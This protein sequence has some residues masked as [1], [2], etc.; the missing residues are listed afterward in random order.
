MGEKRGGGH[1]FRKGVE[2]GERPVTGDERSGSGARNGDG[3]PLSVRNGTSRH[4][5]FVNQSFRIANEAGGNGKVATGF[6]RARHVFYRENGGAS[7]YGHRSTSCGPIGN[8]TVA[9]R[10]ELERIVVGKV[11]RKRFRKRKGDA[12]TAD[13][14]GGS[15]R[16]ISYGVGGNRGRRRSDR[17]RIESVLLIRVDPGTVLSGSARRKERSRRIGNEGVR[18][19]RSGT[20]K[21]A[22][23]SENL[24]DGRI[25]NGGSRQHEDAVFQKRAGFGFRRRRPRYVKIP[26]GHSGTGISKLGA[27]RSR[28]R[29]EVAVFQR[30]RCNRGRGSVVFGN[31]NRGLAHVRTGVVYPYPHGI[32][33]GIIGESGVRHDDFLFGIGRFVRSV[34]RKVDAVY[35]DGVGSG[36]RRG[37]GD[38]GVAG[39]DDGRVG[40][41]LYGRGYRILDDRKGHLSKRRFGIGYA[42]GH[43]IG[44]VLE[45]CRGHDRDQGGIGGDGS[46]DDGRSR[47]AR[48]RRSS[49][50]GVRT[51][52][53]GL[54]IE[55]HVV[56]GSDGNG[57]FRGRTH[58]HHRSRRLLN[59]DEYGRNFRIREPERGVARSCDVSRG[60][61]DSYYRVPSCRSGRRNAVERNR[62]DVA[63]T[64]YRIRGFRRRT[65]DGGEIDGKRRRTSLQIGAA[66][67]VDDRYGEIGRIDAVIDDR[68]LGKRGRTYVRKYVDLNARRVRI[69]SQSFGPSDRRNVERRMGIAFRYGK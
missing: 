9:R 47:S 10:S 24:V 6:R 51:G 65:S 50:N 26:S 2:H 59:A 20:G 61:D 17:R 13:E 19:Y 1:R 66:V 36:F 18:N 46:A 22:N 14:R 28:I 40:W 25:G 37:K 3:G 45:I 33:S 5:I 49:V 52:L 53:A 35:G 67:L 32:R 7:R 38:F 11:G 42:D 21:I 29:E 39:S 15:E 68:R 31:G 44:A 64:R 48:G 27:L 63:V 69:R 43:G 58:R 12:R 8:E 30:Y 41:N 55:R 4:A 62:C 23:G 16:R 54:P 34:E 60:V 57:G 56:E